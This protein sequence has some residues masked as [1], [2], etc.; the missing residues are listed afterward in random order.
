MQCSNDGSKFVSLWALQPLGPMG[1]K[2]EVF[3][4]EHETGAPPTSL[5]RTVFQPYSPKD[6]PLIGN[7]FYDFGGRSD[8]GW[9]D[10]DPIYMYKRRYAR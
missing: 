1:N 6:D 7:I 10:K 9:P 8:D 2:I 5:R 4:A 3:P